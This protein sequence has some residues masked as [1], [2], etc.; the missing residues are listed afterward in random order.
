MCAFLF[1]KEELAGV[2]LFDLCPLDGGGRRQMLRRA[3]SDREAAVLKLAAPGGELDPDKP[4]AW[5][6][7]EGSW[8]TLEATCWRNRLYVVPVLIKQFFVHGD[9][10][11][12][13]TAWRLALDWIEK[14][15]K[16]ENAL[17]DYYAYKIRILRWLDMQP[18]WRLV[19]FSW[20][21]GPGRA[22][23]TAAER[24]TVAAA[25]EEH[26]AL[27][28][29]A[30]TMSRRHTG[31][32]Y[33]FQGATLLYAAGASD[34]N[35]S[36]Y[37]EE[38]IRI[39]KWYAEG[40]F[41]KFGSNVEAAPSYQAFF[42]A[43]FRDALLWAEA[44]GEEYE[45]KA[46]TALAAG[47]R[48]LDYVAQPDGT[49]PSLNDG[50]ELSLQA[51]TSAVRR[52]LS[53]R[54]KLLRLIEARKTAAGKPAA[55]VFFPASR[56]SVLHDEKTNSPGA[57]R[58]TEAMR[59]YVDC[60]VP[61]GHGHAGKPS[62]HVL[63]GKT[64]ILLDSGVCDYDHERYRTYYKKSEAHNAVTVNGGG[65][66]LEEDRRRTPSQRAR[67]VLAK[68]FVGGDYIYQRYVSDGFYPAAYTRDLLFIAPGALLVVDTLET[69]EKASFSQLWHPSGNIQVEKRGGSMLVSGEEDEAAYA[70]ILFG[71]RELCE[72]Q[73]FS[74][75]E[76]GEAKH[77]I[78]EYSMKGKGRLELAALWT[79]GDQHGGYLRKLYLPCGD[80]YEVGYCRKKGVL[81]LRPRLGV[82]S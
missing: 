8:K 52:Q 70:G 48:Y 75:T 7:D 4:I 61:G 77:R 22:C 14:N 23:A 38:G 57:T 16:P 51:F 41:D 13:R 34:E 81:R 40:E 2:E 43:M 6:Q 50:Q 56:L 62:L 47:L 42:T 69:E 3:G 28:H 33:A 58:A 72:R 78:L 45:E 53:L 24:E 66:F 73:G 68:S 71:G 35:R 64:P 36:K 55:G 54:P 46:A 25:L 17:L 63:A 79:V 65:D 20:L 5:G 18:S 39:I 26:A 19:A 15:P 27:V 76:T 31:N 10:T 82:E 74:A 37:F 32:H 59:I 80:A 12:G 67:P 30:A 21:L 29:A 11:A 9:E 60:A 49:A 1:T 44:L